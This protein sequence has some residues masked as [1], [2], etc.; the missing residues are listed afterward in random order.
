VFTQRSPAAS[1][2]RPGKHKLRAHLGAQAVQEAVAI[3]AD[4]L[5]LN[6]CMSSHIQLNARLRG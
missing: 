2:E 1:G 5:W 3:D 6:A 4:M